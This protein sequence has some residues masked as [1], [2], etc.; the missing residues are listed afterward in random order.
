MSQQSLSTG[1]P[2]FSCS[3]PKPAR[4]VPTLHLYRTLLVLNTRN[5]RSLVINLLFLKT[6]IRSRLLIN[7]TF[8]IILKKAICIKPR[9]QIIVVY[10]LDLYRATCFTLSIYL[11][12]LIM[13][14]IK[15][16]YC[17]FFTKE[18]FKNIYS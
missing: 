13:S 8:F 5:T 18:V 9:K 2:I 10:T 14:T 11:K 4:V 17:S 3:I 12:F 1:C 6:V 16:N 7:M 15:L